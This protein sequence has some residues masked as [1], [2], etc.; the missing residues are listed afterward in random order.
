MV[1]ITS[2]AS[3]SREDVASVS[4]RKWQKKDSSWDMEMPSV[5]LPNA[6]QENVTNQGDMLVPVPKY[7]GSRSSNAS[8]WAS[9]WLELLSVCAPTWRKA[10]ESCR[11]GSGGLAGVTVHDGDQD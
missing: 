8:G 9:R 4:L 2:S 11:T 1:Y 5:P 3:E 10:G 6:V 7:V